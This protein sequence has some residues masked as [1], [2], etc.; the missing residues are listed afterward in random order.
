MSSTRTSTPEYG[1]GRAQ[2]GQAVTQVS[3]WA[4]RP[5]RTAA[6]AKKLRRWPVVPVLILIV[7]I[8]G[9]ALAPLIAPHNARVGSLADR[10]RPPVW[11]DQGSLKYILGTDSQGRDIV[12]RLLWGGRI[13]FTVAA[14]TLLIGGW[15][16]TALGMASGYFG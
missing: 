16:G 12:S 9:S 11:Q 7:L 1:T 10:H 2:V 14:V 6:A 8:C 4:R 13:S 3:A 5:G 15:V